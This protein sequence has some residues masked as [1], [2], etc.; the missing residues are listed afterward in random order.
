MGKGD[1]AAAAAA[2]L[3][4]SCPILLRELGE[5]RRAGRGRLKEA[6]WRSGMEPVVTAFCQ[7]C[8]I[9]NFPH[10]IRALL[11]KYQIGC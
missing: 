2:V 6:N 7:W 4:V 10:G 8:I 5:L 9:L 3:S 11:A 1:A